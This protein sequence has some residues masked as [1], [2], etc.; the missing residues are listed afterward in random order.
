MNNEVQ[1]RWDIRCIWYRL[2]PSYS[3]SFPVRN[4]QSIYLSTSAIH[5]LLTQCNGVLFEELTS[6]PEVPLLYNTQ[7]HYCVHSMQTPVT[8]LSHL[9]PVRPVSSYLFTLQFVVISHVKQ[10]IFI[11]VSQ[12]KLCIHFLH[13]YTCQ[14]PPQP[15]VIFLDFKTLIIFNDQCQ[16]LFPIKTYGK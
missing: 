14:I 12:Q 3:K 2:R 4:S 6:T 16:I 13:S 7:F 5:F 8:I 15:N 11:P 10:C 9:N 1:H